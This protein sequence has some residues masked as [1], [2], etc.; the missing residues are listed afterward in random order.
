ML[1]IKELLLGLLLC[2]SI[3]LASHFLGEIVPSLGAASFAIFI[4]IFLGNTIF[5][6]KKYLQGSKFSETDLLAYSIVLMGGTLSISSII[7]IKFN[8]VLFIVLQMI[9]TILV[10]LILGK[11]L[12]FN[13]KYT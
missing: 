11:L 12:K 2:I 9:G 1:K 6:H 7:A 10:A 8:G 5:K 3:A 13:K 4:G